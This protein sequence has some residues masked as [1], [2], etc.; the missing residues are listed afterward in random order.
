M[1]Q[2]VN[3]S[4][5]NNPDLK[6][7][8]TKDGKVCYIKLDRA[9]CIGAGSCVALAPETFGLDEENLVYLKED[10]TPYDNLEEV[11]A[12]AQSCPVFAIEVYDEQLK[13]IWPE[14]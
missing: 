7:I 3:Q 1:D 2:N 10:G 5:Q 14:N 13:K 11:I 6:K 4:T 12:G 9:V 8:M